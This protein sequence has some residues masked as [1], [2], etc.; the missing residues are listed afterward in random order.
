MKIPNFLYPGTAALLT[1]LVLLSCTAD[2][3]PPIPQETVN[4]T[5]LTQEEEPDM[6]PVTIPSGYTHTFAEG[7][8]AE[9][10]QESSVRAVRF[11]PFLPDR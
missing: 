11:F 10:V 6:Q 1:A 2:E 7:T 5:E 3:P 4:S 8:F 9:S